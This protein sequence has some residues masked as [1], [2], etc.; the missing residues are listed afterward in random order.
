[1]VTDGQFSS[2]AQ[3][4]PTLRPHG[5]QHTRLSCPSPTP[6]A[7]SKLMSIK[8]VMPSNHL[9]LCRLLLLPHSSLVMVIILQCIQM[10]NHYIETN[11]MLYV[12]DNS[13]IIILIKDLGLSFSPGQAITGLDGSDLEL[14]LN[15]YIYIYIYI[16]IS[17]C[18]LLY[19]FPL[20]PVS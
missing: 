17:L 12:N 1:M 19:P 6:R 16:Y 10:L 3:L 8:S 5:L 15:I 14:E 18:D 9:I 13:T 4:C 20:K 2:V 7:Y 11:I